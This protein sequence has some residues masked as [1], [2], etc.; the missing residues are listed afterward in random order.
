MNRLGIDV[1]TAAAEHLTRFLNS[2]GISAQVNSVE[3][4]AQD[5]DYTFIHVDTALT[6]AELDNLLYEKFSCPNGATYV[7]V[8]ERESDD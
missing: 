1:E 4:Y 5:R 2:C 7:G 8:F 3:R 6:E